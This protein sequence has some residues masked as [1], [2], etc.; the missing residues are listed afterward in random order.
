MY[1]G[2]TGLGHLSGTLDVGVGVVAFGY[3]SIAA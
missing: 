2:A 1:S 3:L